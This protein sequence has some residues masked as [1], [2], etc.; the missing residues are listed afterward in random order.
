[1]TGLVICC[2]W[3]QNMDPAHRRSHQCISARHSHIHPSMRSYSCYCWLAEIWITEESLGPVAGPCGWSGGFS[4]DWRT[5][6]G[7]VL[8][9]NQSSRIQIAYRTET[10]WLMIWM[11]VEVLL[12]IPNGIMLGCQVST[13]LRTSQ[14]TLSH[15]AVLPCRRIRFVITRP[16]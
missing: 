1:M 3:L 8:Y 13:L 14:E 10:F 6:T 15:E 4:P 16:Y 7:P 2:H 5:R 12:F 9:S 11:V